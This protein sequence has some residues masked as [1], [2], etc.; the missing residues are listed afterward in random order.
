MARI[1]SVRRGI[2]SPLP[3]PHYWKRRVKDTG[4]KA[5]IM[6]QPHH[7]RIVVISDRHAVKS[8]LFERLCA[9]LEGGATA[10]LLREKDLPGAE[11]YRLGRALRR[12][13][14]EH[15]AAL[16]VSDRV[17]LALAVE[18]DGAHL[19]WQSLPIEAAR[20]AAGDRLWI[21]FSA[22]NLTEAERAASEGANYLTY[23]P[24]FQ[25]PSKEGLVPTVGLEGLRAA[26]AVTRLP[27]VALGGVTP[28]NA[29][30]C[31]EAGAAGV[32]MIRSVLQSSDP[33][34]TVQRFVEAIPTA[35]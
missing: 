15:G 12:A 19:G 21:G 35:A 17:D 31:I 29:A 33:K 27:L 6:I 16:L 25:T 11:L 5:T 32:A 8:D 20:R 18:A 22:H 3:L 10:I 23:S 34:A 9:A 1:E 30:S 24:I 14:L 28:E 4:E 26:A 2:S 7:L 13:T